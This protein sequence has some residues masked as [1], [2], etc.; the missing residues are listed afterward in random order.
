MNKKDY[1]APEFLE[2]KK[3]NDSTIVWILGCLIVIF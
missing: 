3:T 2:G 1:V